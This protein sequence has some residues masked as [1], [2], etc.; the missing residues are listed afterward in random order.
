M[1]HGQVLS[2][3]PAVGLVVVWL[4]L[5]GR[6]FVLAQQGVETDHSFA[7]LVGYTSHLSV[8]RELIILYSVYSWDCLYGLLYGHRLLWARGLLGAN[9]EVEVQQ[10]DFSLGLD[11][12]GFRLFGNWELDGG[13]LGWLRLGL[14]GRL[15]F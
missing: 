6:L 5:L 9:V 8:V 3:E 13:R 11:R 15:H 1:V 4:G 10:A 2:L 12:D 14:S 7:R